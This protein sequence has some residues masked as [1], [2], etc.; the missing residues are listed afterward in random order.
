MKCSTGGLYEKL[1][2]HSIFVNAGKNIGHFLHENL[3]GFLGKYPSYITYPSSHVKDVGK[4]CEILGFHHGVVEIFALLEFC[5]VLVDGV[6]HISGQYISPIFR[7]KQCRKN[8]GKSGCL[9]I[10]GQCRL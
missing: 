6:P 7:V 8:T 1:L 10:Q 5:M 9:N 4:V 3:H 2:S